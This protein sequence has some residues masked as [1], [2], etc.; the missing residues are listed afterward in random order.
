MKLVHT[1][2]KAEKLDETERAEAS[3]AYDDV[4]AGVDLAARRSGSTDELPTRPDGT[5]PAGPTQ[6]NCFLCKTRFGVCL[7]A[8]S[9]ASARSASPSTPLTHG[10]RRRTPASSVASTSAPSASVVSAVSAA[11]ALLPACKMCER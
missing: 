10:R 9:C 5:T 11:T 4:E 2:G 3:Q 8:P 7:P 1:T 6:I